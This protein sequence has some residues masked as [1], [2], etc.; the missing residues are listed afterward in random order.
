MTPVA[1][2]DSLNAARFSS[3]E[4]SAKIVGQT[5]WSARVPLDPLFA[6]GSISSKREDRPGG[7][8][9][10]GGPRHN[11][12]RPS[13]HGEHGAELKPAPQVGC[14]K[15]NISYRRALLS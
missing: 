7:R 5:P 1:Q 11:F 2:A 12:C 4:N 13:G 6:T 9:R 14:G 8:P 3:C 10:T 15:S